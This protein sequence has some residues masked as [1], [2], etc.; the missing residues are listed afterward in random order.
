MIYK[1]CLIKMYNFIKMIIMTI[2][3][4]I[5]MG[6]TMRITMEIIM[7]INNFIIIIILEIQ[8]KLM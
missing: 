4:G 3:M 1:D 5:T 8:I 2:V 7:G 6:V